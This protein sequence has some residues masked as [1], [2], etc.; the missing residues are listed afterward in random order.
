MCNQLPSGSISAA[1]QTLGLMA[2]LAYPERCLATQPS[3][4]SVQP[5]RCQEWEILWHD[6]LHTSFIRSIV[7]ALLFWQTFGTLWNMGRE[8]LSDATMPYISRENILQSLIVK[9]KK[10]DPNKGSSSFCP[11]L[12]LFIILSVL[13]LHHLPCTLVP[14]ACRFGCT[15]SCIC[16]L[17]YQKQETFWHLLIGQ[18]CWV[19]VSWKSNCNLT[20]ENSSPA[21]S[22][23]HVL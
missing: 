13:S 22:A 10:G 23:L 4:A 7:L 1:S 14:H 6:A 2:S 12:S 21:V 11:M 15:S 16:G 9:V 17:Y 8:Q 20:L 3:G 19:F 18:W 5:N